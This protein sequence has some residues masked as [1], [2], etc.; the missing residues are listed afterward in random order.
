MTE[1]TRPETDRPAPES[2]AAPGRA[3]RR[4][5]TRTRTSGAFRSL[6]AGAVVLALLLI[7]I[8]E[9][10]QRVKVS[11]LGATGHLPLGVALLFAAV[12]GAL[13]LGL[14]GTVRI[15]QLRRRV[16]RRVPGDPARRA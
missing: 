5:S 8:L 9:N 10:T 1:P 7:F 2:A 3:R 16:K 11:Y 6:L 4:L 13:L 15:L 12:A 14:V